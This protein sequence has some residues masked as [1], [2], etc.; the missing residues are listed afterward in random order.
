MTLDEKKTHVLR[1][2]RLGMDF[3]TS[4]LVAECSEPEL[5]ALEEDIEFQRRISI[6]MALEEHRLLSKHNAVIEEAAIRG[7]GAPIQWRLEKLN[8]RRYGNKESGG[9]GNA[10]PRKILYEIAEP[11]K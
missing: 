6:E 10:L 1:C 4:S 8:P 7:N 5:T 2:I 11:L 3:T 9:T